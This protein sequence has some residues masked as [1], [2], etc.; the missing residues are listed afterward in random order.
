L[1]LLVA[2]VQRAV[3]IQAGPVYE[4]LAI[5]ALAG[6]VIARFQHNP[7]KPK[8]KEHKA[9]GSLSSSST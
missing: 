6:I 9:N 1:L 4:H 7:A 8:D 3:C 2:E 5:L